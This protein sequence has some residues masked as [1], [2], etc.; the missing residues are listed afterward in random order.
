MKR[1][2]RHLM[3]LVL[4]MILFSACK[5]SVPKD[6]IQPDDMEDMLYDYHLSQSMAQR[7][8][9]NSDYTRRLYFEAVLKKYGVTQAEFDSSLVYYY[10]RADRLSEIYQRVQKR[11]SDDAVVLGASVS[12]VNRYN[13]QSLSGDTTDVWE[14]ARFAMLMPHRPY[15]VMQFSQ[16][17]DTSYHAGDSFL[18]TFGSSYLTQSGN[19]TATLYLAV[20][21]DND[22]TVALN[23]VVSSYGS[24]TLRVSP[25]KERVKNIK[26]FILVGQRKEE[27][28]TDN[29]YLLFL[30]RIQLIRFHNK[31]VDEPVAVSTTDSVNTAKPDSVKTDSAKLPVRRRLGDRPQPTMK[32]EPNRPKLQLNKPITR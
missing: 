8:N 30:D 5:P 3:L 26:G 6:V 21:Y 31:M 1:G 20:T 23:T 17:A 25:C 2:G 13:T 19:K 9:G 18:M 32:A 15:N 16:K 14:G 29:M 27:Q 4:G 12:E 28:T 7:E 10:T 11:L 22:S 24:T